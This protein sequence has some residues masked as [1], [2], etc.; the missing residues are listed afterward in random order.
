MLQAL[1]AARTPL[2]TAQT[3]QALDLG[4]GALL[5]VICVGKRGGVLLLE[6]RS[7]RFLL[8]MG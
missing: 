4:Q 2:M 6:W 5:K 8:P 1:N 7:F 3:G